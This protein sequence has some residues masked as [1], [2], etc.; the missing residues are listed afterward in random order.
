MRQGLFAFDGD[1]FVVHYQE[2]P[3]LD[4]VGWFDAIGLPSHGPGYDALLRGKVLD[5]ID[6]DRVIVGFYNAAYLSNRRFTQVVKAFELD[7]DRV[8]EKRLS[9]AYS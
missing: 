3:D 9:E 6:A 1:R 2:K 8:V 5:D 7:E 4:H